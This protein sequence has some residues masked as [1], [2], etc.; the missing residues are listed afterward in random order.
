MFT[1]WLR[2]E[3]MRLGLP[4]IEVDTSISEDELTELVARSFG[5]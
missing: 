3:T 1:D 2:A 4:T 5:L